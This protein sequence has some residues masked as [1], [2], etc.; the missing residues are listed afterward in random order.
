MELVGVERRRSQPAGEAPRLPGHVP[1][2]SSL[3]VLVVDDSPSVRRVVT[4]FLERSGWQTTAAKDGID[5]LE[6]LA[7]IHPDV[8][9]VDIEMPRMN[10]YELLTQ[11]RGDPALQNIPV[12]FLTSRS[13][14]KHRQRAEQLLVDG[15]LIKPYREDEMLEELMRVTRK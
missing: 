13:A 1:S 7:S 4:S 10:G 12:V 5:A 15:Y 2:K 8:A 3:H 14:I 9:L 11:I 6:K